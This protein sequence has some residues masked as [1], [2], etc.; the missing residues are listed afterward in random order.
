MNTQGDHMNTPKILIR[1][2]DFG[3]S[4]GTNEAIIDGIDTGT[5]RNIGILTVGPHIKHCLDALIERADDVCIGLHCA[6]NSEWDAV[7]WG[8]ISPADTVPSLVYEDGTFYK[9]NNETHENARLEEIIIEIEAQLA[10][11]RKLGLEPQYL[12]THM[13]FEWIEGVHDA[14]LAICKR[15]N[16]IFANDTSL[17]QTQFKSEPDWPE[18]TPYSLFESIVPAKSDIAQVW[19]L[20]PAYSKTITRKFGKDVQKRR[21]SEARLLIN[22]EFNAAAEASGYELLRYDDVLSPC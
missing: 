8:P 6:L 21:H 7:R 3:A 20:H 9:S 2:D 5:I 10:Q 19:V 1:A 11:L 18:A 4:P 17:V 12:D 22:P 13:G 16:L 14:L 15:E